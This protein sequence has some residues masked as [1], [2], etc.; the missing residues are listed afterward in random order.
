MRMKLAHTM[1]RVKDLDATLDFYTDFIG[2][3][4]VRRKPIGD[5][6][7]LVWLE[8]R[9]GG[10]NIE[11]TYNHGKGDYTLGDQFGHLAFFADDLDGVIR[12]VERRGWWYRKSRPELGSRY[13]FLKDPNGYDVE[14]LQR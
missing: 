5:E 12:E 7:T 3:R 11:L 14:I 4:E 9:D 1:I 13:I 10:Y 8:D 2:L 6:A